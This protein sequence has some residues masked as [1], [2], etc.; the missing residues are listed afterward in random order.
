MP[1]APADN[2]TQG[3]QNR[4]GNGYVK[5]EEV[6][7]FKERGGIIIDIDDKI[8]SAAK[9]SKR[10]IVLPFGSIKTY[11]VEER[12]LKIKPKVKKVKK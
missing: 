7:N 8:C 1:Y 11:F 12:F 2:V 5:A 10:Y 4:D 6:H 3:T 9:G